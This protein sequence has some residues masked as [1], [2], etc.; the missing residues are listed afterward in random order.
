MVTSLVQD[1]IAEVGEVIDVYAALAIDETYTVTALEAGDAPIPDAGTLTATVPG[2]YLYNVTTL[3]GEL[4]CLLRLSV[5][6]YLFAVSGY[7]PGSALQLADETLGVSL[8]LGADALV[9]GLNLG[10]GQSA[11]LSSEALSEALADLVE[12]D[13]LP[14]DLTLGSPATVSVYYYTEDN[15]VVERYDALQEDWI[16]IG[17]SYD[18]AESL[19]SFS[20]QYL[21]RYRIY[22]QEED[23][24][25]QSD[26]SSSATLAAGAGGGGGGGGCFIGTAGF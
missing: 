25:P 12:F 16:S 7:E 14:F 26:T 11:D 5:T 10:I 19:V 8:W 22:A 20:T 21:G 24:N 4:F 3:E 1:F 15:P 17:S 9:Q 23:E 13:L 6:E 18:V 2:T